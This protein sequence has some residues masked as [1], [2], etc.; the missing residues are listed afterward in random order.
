MA[1]RT[2]EGGIAVRLA[3]FPESEEQDAIRLGERE[4]CLSGLTPYSV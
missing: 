4:F 3:V 2:F 1:R